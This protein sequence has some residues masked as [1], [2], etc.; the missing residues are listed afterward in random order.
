MSDSSV[1]FHSS[2]TVNRMSLCTSLLPAEQ[3]RLWGIPA[4]TSSS[5]PVEMPSCFV[6]VSSALMRSPCLRDSPGPA[7]AGP[8]AD[9]VCSPEPRLISQI[10]RLCCRAETELCCRASLTSVSSSAILGFTLGPLHKM[11]LCEMISQE[12]CHGYDVQGVT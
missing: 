3:S 7:P 11:W 5:I 9:A 12:S 8:T 4:T 2:C 6:L 10:R 1:G